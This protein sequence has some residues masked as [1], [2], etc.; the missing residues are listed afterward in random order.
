MALGGDCKDFGIYCIE[1]GNHCRV[2]SYGVTLI[3]LHFSRRIMDVVL[4]RDEK[5]QGKNQEDQ[6]DAFFRN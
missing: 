1:W 6:L 4:R 5:G 3:A 2:L